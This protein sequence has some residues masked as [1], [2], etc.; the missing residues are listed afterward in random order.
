MWAKLV[1]EVMIIYLS[2]VINN[3]SSFPMFGVLSEKI[4]LNKRAVHNESKG[5]PCNV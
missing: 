4:Y 2:E 3:L 1:K 5:F